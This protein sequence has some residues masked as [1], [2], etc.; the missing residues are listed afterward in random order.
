MR[1]LLAN[2]GFVLQIS[3]IFMVIPIALSFLNDELV[4]TVGFFITATLFLVLGFVF[5]A[6]CERQQLSY[7]SSSALFVLVFVLLSLIGSI[8]YMYV[9]ISNG[10]I[11]QIITDSIFES[12][13]GF[14][15]TGFSVIPDVSVLPESLVFYRA[16]TQF[17]G[18]IGIV[19]VLLAFFY[20]DAKLKD[21]AKLMGF[22]T[23]GKIKKTF[24]LIL[25]VYCVYTGVLIVVSLT[26]GYHDVIKAVSF[27]FSAIA[28]GGFTPIND[29]TSVATSFPMNMV[30]IVGMVLG[31][32]N[33]FIIAGLFKGRFKQLFFSEFSV[34]VVMAAVAISVTTIF[35][36]L[37]LEESVFHIISGM[38]NTGFSYVSVAEFTVGLKLF[39]VFLM[40][41]G[42][43]SFS[44]AG[45][46]KIFRFVLM[47]KALRKALVES[48]TD[49]NYTIKLF[50]R[51]YSDAMVLKA[52]VVV[53]LFITVVFVS[54]FIVSSYGFPLVDSLFETTSATATTGLSVG[55]VTPSLVLELKWL[56]ICL[57]ILGRV[58]ILAFFI[59][60]SRSKKSA[61]EP[62]TTGSQ[63]AERTAEAAQVTKQ[64]ICPQ[65]R[66][67]V[68]VV[69][70]P[71]EN[72]SVLCPSCGAKGIV[73]IQE[74]SL[75]QK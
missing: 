25:L 15:T 42:G 12:A 67:P 36:G 31:A 64:F 55:I 43:A 47:F 73:S 41:V 5:N 7:Q 32:S 40:L 22:S 53:L 13:S 61:V 69:G 23:D 56:F 75:Q 51:T 65:C 44:T 4:A 6:F 26:F 30:L 74:S 48:I 1:A 60:F 46:F 33:F 34:F 8:P 68:T 62:T 28:T 54:A 58:E 39:L 50:G 11:I 52:I 19:L 70:R 24:L 35:F 18:G 21:F 72:H 2:L 9:N 29:I 38:T 66:T 71:G 57:M 49:R 63:V 45:G 59:M 27:V 10:D 37:T 3:G 16:L 14:T 17:I 20:P